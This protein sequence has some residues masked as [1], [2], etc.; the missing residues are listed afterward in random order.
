MRRLVPFCKNTE[1]TDAEDETV[2]GEETEIV[3]ESIKTAEINSQP[4]SLY[5]QKDI[6]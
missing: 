5:R 4:F 3:S 1:K 6:Y 2:S